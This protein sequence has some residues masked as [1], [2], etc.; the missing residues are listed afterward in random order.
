MVAFTNWTKQSLSPFSEWVHPD[1]DLC[2]GH[3]KAVEAVAAGMLTL[4]VQVSVV[5]LTLVRRHLVLL[6]CPIN[7]LKISLP[8]FYT[9]ALC[10]DTTRLLSRNLYRFTPAFAVLCFVSIHRLSLFVTLGRMDHKAVEF[11]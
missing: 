4:F 5:F 3:Q 11:S 8:C 2:H 6:V 9:E 10:F 7:T 1:V